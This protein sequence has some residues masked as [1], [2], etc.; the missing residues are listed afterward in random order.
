MASSTIKNTPYN[1]KSKSVSVTAP[2][3]SIGSATI[4]VTDAE[5]HMI[6]GFA[7]TDTEH[8][9]VMQCFFS[10]DSTINVRVRNGASS[11]Q[12]GTFTVYYC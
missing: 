11:S 12:T 2:T 9:S 10:N 3:Y 4:S 5:Y 8:L 1:T 6:K 7:V